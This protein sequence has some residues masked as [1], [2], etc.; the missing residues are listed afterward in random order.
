VDEWRTAKPGRIQAEI[1]GKL[2]GAVVQSWLTL[3]SWVEGPA[4]SMR[5]LVKGMKGLVSKALWRLATAGAEGLVE[6]LRR[7]VPGLRRLG[8][9]QKGKKDQGKGTFQ[10]L[11]ELRQQRT[12]GPLNEKDSK[13][14]SP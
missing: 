7:A 14:P 12:L 1:Y 5:R 6:A 8:A 3:L 13:A 2:L 9:R 10:R 4:K 11:E